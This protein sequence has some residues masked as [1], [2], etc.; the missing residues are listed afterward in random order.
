MPRKATKRPVKARARRRAKARNAARGTVVTRQRA[1]PIAVGT[2]STFRGPRTTLTTISNSEMV[3]TIYNPLLRSSTEWANMLSVSVNPGL[4]GA[5]PWLSS[6]SNSF[7][8]YRFRRLAFEYVPSCPS[9]SV[10][11]VGMYFDYDPNDVPAP[12]M[13]HLSANRGAVIGNVWAKHA[14]EVKTTGKSFLSRANAPPTAD[15]TNYDCGNFHLALSGVDSSYTGNFGT[16]IVHYTVDLL[17][18]QMSNNTVS[19]QSTQI[20]S[21]AGA[22]STLPLGL[23][24]IQ[25]GDLPIEYDSDTGYITFKE[26][27]SFLVDCSTTSGAINS[28]PPKLNLANNSGLAK[29]EEADAGGGGFWSTVWSV[30]SWLLEVAAGD[31]IQYAL[32]TSAAGAVTETLLTIA[33]FLPL[34]VRHGPDAG[35]AVAKP[36]ARTSRRLEPQPMRH[37]VRRPAATDSTALDLNRLAE[38]V[39]S[40]IMAEETKT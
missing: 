34:L 5:F 18:P 27:G 31:A 40:I 36:I 16:L 7:E 4:A 19:A 38:D 29:A 39:A 24:P 20:V 9:T 12:D 21:G 6:V 11:Q 32:T 14:V 33:P 37:T 8:R 2:S 17:I 3:A 15:K 35:R 10:G 1:A 28:G 23:D 26:P 13:M 25:I 30:G 22:S